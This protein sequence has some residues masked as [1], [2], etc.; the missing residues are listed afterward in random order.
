MEVRHIDRLELSLHQAITLIATRASQQ[1]IVGPT[2][3]TTPM[4]PLERWRLA[5][6]DQFEL[7]F[8]WVLTLMAT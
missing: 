7:S 6:N 5:H 4:E 8:H 3:T 2:L 1:P